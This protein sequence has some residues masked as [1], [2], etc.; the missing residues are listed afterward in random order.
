MIVRRKKRGPGEP[1]TRGARA[2]VQASFRSE[3]VALHREIFRRNQVRISQSV[4]GYTPA[5]RQYEREYQN[6][7]K[8]FV[9]QAAFAELDRA[10]AGATCVYVGDYHTLAQAQR[11]FLRL[12]RRLPE[13]RPVTLALEFIL[14]KHQK[15][16]DG[17]LGGRIS[18]KS[19]RRRLEE[20]DHWEF[21][22]WHNFRE[23]FEIAKRRGYRVVG[24]DSSGH[25]PAGATLKARD[26]YAA[27]IIGKERKARPDALVMVLIGELHIAKEHLPA[28]VAT[29]SK[30]AE[31][32][33]ILYQNCEE[34]YWKL[35]EHGQEHEVEL[36]LV[37]EGSFCLL[38]TPPIVCQQSFLNWLDVDEGI[39]ELAAPEQNFKEYARLV[40]SF[41]DLPLGDALDEVE[42]ASVVDLSFLSRLKRRGD[43]STNDVREI[44][45]QI[46]RSESYYI[47][48]ARMVYLGN[49][50]VNHA[51]EEA[52]HFM[53]HLC[54]GSHEPRGLVDAFYARCLEEAMGFLGSKLVNHKRKCAHLPHFE[55]LAR[56]RVTSPEERELARL[57]I[58]HAKME[59]GERPR[60]LARIY[61]T[62]A[63]LFNAVTHV[64]GYRLGDKLYYALVRGQMAKDDI[65]S[66]FFDAWEEEGAALTTYLY[67]SMRTRDVKVPER[68]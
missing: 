45:K 51:S 2:S 21:G 20:H 64:I 38:N 65:R 12:V 32:P 55:R 31:R 19:F 25:G 60:G 43:F 30:A 23:L 22:G 44:K 59:Q 10:I 3:I 56:S 28:A 1:R 58:L 34:I 36:V 13:G 68:F 53:R 37:E 47:P 46:L 29:R 62:D 15:A 39:P 41:F 8:Q 40:A 24:I 5:F 67:L 63:D 14:G 26:D 48:R 27:R 4:V 57:V 18:E 17:Y 52:T 6:G 16:V 42:L 61:E 9:R 11:S 50:S 33:L 54:S 66:L 49:L 35:E 7:V